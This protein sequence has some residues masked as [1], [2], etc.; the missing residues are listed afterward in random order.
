MT[1]LQLQ[2]SKICLASLF[3]ALGWLMPF[4]TGQIAQLGSA[5]LPMHIPVLITGFVLGPWYGLFIG[6][7]VPITRSLMFGMPPIYP[8]S[9]SMAFELATYGFMCGFLFQLIYKK[10]KKINIYANT[11]ISLC[12]SLLAGRIIYGIVM[13]I[14]MLSDKNVKF[15]WATYINGV[16]LNAWIGILI[17][18]IFIPALVI[19]LYKAKLL[20]KYLSPKKDDEGVKV[21]KL[22]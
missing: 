21:E 18:L 9:I 17:Q 3:I 6:F 10:F 4:L 7:T 5:L 20:Q 2:I 16:L 12:S 14:L 11:Y 13:C 22:Y 8:T 15:T 1:K 19:I